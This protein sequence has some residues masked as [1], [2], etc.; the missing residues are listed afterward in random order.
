MVNVVLGVV[1]KEDKI[2]LIKR[3]KGDFI[4]LWGIPGG[5]VEECEHIDVAVKRE[6]QEE[7]G[8]KM[9]FKKLLGV[10]TEV[11]H[12]TNKTSILYVC[13]M[14]IQEGEE[15]ENTEFEYRWFSKDEILNTKQVIGSDKVLLNKFYTMKQENYIKL[16]CYRKENGEYYWK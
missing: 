6:M 14:R 5:K 8:V 12:D 11:M 3:E 16:D 9:D 15:I 1:E 4:G 10:A 2:L 7:I 13:L